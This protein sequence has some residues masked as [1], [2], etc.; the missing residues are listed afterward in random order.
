MLDLSVVTHRVYVSAY[1]PVVNYREVKSLLS[2][3]HRNTGLN[4]TISRSTK[5]LLHLELT[6]DAD[7]RFEPNRKAYR[8]VL[9]TLRIHGEVSTN[10]LRLIPKSRRRKASVQMSPLT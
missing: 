8:F 10:S 9:K 5:K 7:M 1:V 3:F 4:L 6:G 2:S